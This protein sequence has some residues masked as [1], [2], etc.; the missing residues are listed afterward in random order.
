MSDLKNSHYTLR[1]E[2]DQGRCSS[3]LGRIPRPHGRGLIPVS[4]GGKLSTGRCCLS[5]LTTTPPK[6]WGGGLFTGRSHTGRPLLTSWGKQESHWPGG[7]RQMT[8]EAASSGL[9][10]SHA[11]IVGVGSWKSFCADLVLGNQAVG[12]WGNGTAWAWWEEHP[13]AR[14]TH[15]SSVPLKSSRDRDQHQP[16]CK[17]D[18][19]RAPAHDPKASSE[20]WIWSWGSIYW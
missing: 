12:V 10:S 17:R 20:E 7:A 18:I 16:D 14:E 1:P 6:E 15:L 2:R 11:C 5:K 4:L 19:S 13:L 8:R 3:Q 9:W